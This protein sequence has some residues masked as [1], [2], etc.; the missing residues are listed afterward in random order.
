MSAENGFANASMID[1]VLVGNMP[2]SVIY[3]SRM[4]ELDA[5]LVILI[6]L[7]HSTDV[8]CYFGCLI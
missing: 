8:C 4:D 6:S 5:K 7:A 2:T 3:M 1:N